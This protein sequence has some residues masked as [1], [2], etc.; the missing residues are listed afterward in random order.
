MYYLEARN[1]VKQ[2][3][4]HK[5]LDNVTIQVP[6]NSIYGL[7][8]PN[9]AGKTTL[10]KLILRLYDPQNGEILYNGINLKEYS[11]D[12]LRKRTVS[13]F[14]DYRIFAGTIAENVVAG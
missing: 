2:Y 5:A 4:S 11:I 13:V 8:G 6:E 7:L 1:I 3:A 10:T 14:Q 9:G 12:E